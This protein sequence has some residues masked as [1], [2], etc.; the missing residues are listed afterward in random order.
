MLLNHS[1]PGNVRELENV[2][3]RAIVIGET[4]TIIPEDL[5]APDSFSGAAEPG[6][7]YA[8]L[9][10]A[11]LRAYTRAIIQSKGDYKK[12]CKI[13]KVHERAFHRTVTSLGLDELLKN[14]LESNS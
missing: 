11:K 8:E 5:L 13:L 9:H 4:D 14:Q 2:V 7:V 10:A 6:G 3:E 12:A 1:W